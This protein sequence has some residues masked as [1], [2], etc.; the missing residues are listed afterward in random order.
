MVLRMGT[1]VALFLWVNMINPGPCFHN[2]NHS[3][4]EFRMY[5]WLFCGPNGAASVLA[6]SVCLQSRSWL[7]ALFVFSEFSAA[8][9]EQVFRTM[10][11]SDTYQDAL[12][13]LYV[14]FGWQLFCV[15]YR[16][17][18]TSRLQSRPMLYSP[19]PLWLWI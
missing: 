9:G 7:V 14:L 16:V 3:F 6:H 17:S 18:S 19:S 5:H 1:P 4:V 2:S 8:D 15:F 11:T 12:R 10:G 13:H